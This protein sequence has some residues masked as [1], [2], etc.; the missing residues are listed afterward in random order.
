MYEMIIGN[1]KKIMGDKDFV[2]VDFS[3][4]ESKSIIFACFGGEE[5]CKTS[6]PEL[7]AIIYQQ[8]SSSIDGNK[9]MPTVIQ[10]C[11]EN[12]T[13]T[14]TTNGLS[15]EVMGGKVAEQCFIDA[16][17][18]FRETKMEMRHI[19]LVTDA[20]DNI[21]QVIENVKSNTTY[22]STKEEIS[23]LI[24]GDTYCIYMLSFE[25]DEETASAH[26]EILLKRDYQYKVKYCIATRTELLSPYVTK[27]NTGDVV[28][29]YNM[30]P[31]FI[32]DPDFEWPIM[33]QSEELIEERKQELVLDVIGNIY[34]DDDYEFSSI[35]NNLI[36][37]Q[38]RTQKGMAF[39][40]NG[41]N[42]TSDIRL[43]F[44]DSD[45]IINFTFPREWEGVVP[46]LP[47]S[48]QDKA[49]LIMQFTICALKKSTNQIV[50]C[51][52]SFSNGYDQTYDNGN[53]CYTPLMSMI[54]GYFLL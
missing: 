22:L 17:S 6:Y 14:Y 46:T 7:Y 1:L 23:G 2:H 31:L 52:F 51:E 34:L 13:F 53:I 41:V 50:E 28:I 29:Q 32:Y 37:M 42:G 10:D 4:E 30:S 36:M 5:M 35:K 38:L 12:G 18:V 16:H 21:V 49:E 39:F 44:N 20:N 15:L 8:I 24:F 27:K 19:I 9:Y 26:M 54:W 45:N 25:I 47:L 43:C 40:S 11:L 48:P 3:E 33:Y